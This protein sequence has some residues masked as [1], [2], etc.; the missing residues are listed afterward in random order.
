V[1]FILSS[2]AFHL[3]LPPPPEDLSPLLPDPPH[4]TSAFLA[5]T[6]FAQ[7]G[8]NPAWL[9]LFSP[10]VSSHPNPL[11]EVSYFAACL[12]FSCVGVSTLQRQDLFFF[13]VEF[14]LTFPFCIG[15]LKPGHQTLQGL[16]CRELLILRSVL[17]DG[18]RLVFGSPH[19]FN[20]ETSNI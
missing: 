19:L 3:E 13:P 2:R 9:D 16:L 14:S 10:I 18:A 20:P 8:H 12:R 6:P 5:C 15:S 4:Y 7:K 17:S 1:A 11:A